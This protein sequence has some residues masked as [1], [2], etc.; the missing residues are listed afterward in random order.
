MDSTRSPVVVVEES[1]VSD[2]VANRALAIYCLGALDEVRRLIDI[3]GEERLDLAPDREK[4][5]FTLR[6]WIS[7]NAEQ[8]RK[9]YDPTKGGAGILLSM[10]KYRPK[11]AER[12]SILLHDFSEKDIRSPE[13]YELLGQYLASDKV[14]IAELACYHL[15]RL[16]GLRLPQF[17]AALPKEWR[18]AMAEEVDKL[19]KD[20]KL[21]PPPPS[22]RPAG[23][24]PA[25]PPQPPKK[26]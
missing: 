12:L 22:S 20:G 23:P 14:A 18:Q 11:E 9:L 8:S 5:I 4:I 26:P 21:P 1:Q 3:L 13:T 15:R 19:V 10:K 7:R 17:N 25:T 6:R 2:H 24:A 16:A